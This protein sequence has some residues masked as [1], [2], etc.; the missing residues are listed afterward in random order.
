MSIVLIDS[1]LQIKKIVFHLFNFANENWW[2][3]TPS[4][5]KCIDKS[6]SNTHT[7]TH[8]HWESRTTE[9][10]RKPTRITAKMELIFGKWAENWKFSIRNVMHFAFVVKR[11]TKIKLNFMFE[12][13]FLFFFCFQLKH[14]LL[15]LWICYLI[16]FPIFTAFTFLSLCTMHDLS[17]ICLFC[18]IETIFN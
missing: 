4:L 8:T 11:K 3:Q 13:F 15:K 2:Q 18:T 7:Y 17:S 16:S 9:M 10:K 1:W 5:I 12:S 6:D 14:N